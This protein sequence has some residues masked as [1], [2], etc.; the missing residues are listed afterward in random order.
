MASHR[1]PR[2]SARTRAG[3][4]RGDGAVYISP[5]NVSNSPAPVAA[6]MNPQQMAESLSRMSTASWRVTPQAIRWISH[7]ESHPFVPAS[8]ASMIGR[9]GNRQ[10]LTRA[11]RGEETHPP[12]PIAALTKRRIERFADMILVI[13]GGLNTISRDKPLASWRIV[14]GIGLRLLDVISL[15][16]R[17]DI[18]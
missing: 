5:G 11:P 15:W 13:R 6:T 18:A 10:I 7:K 16:G 8:R 12:H 4:D 9:A 3:A 1:N 17:S 2:P 14:S